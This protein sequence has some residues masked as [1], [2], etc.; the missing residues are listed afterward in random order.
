MTEPA[1]L[2]PAEALA[3]ARAQLAAAGISHPRREAYRLW[4]ELRDRPEAEFGGAV[5]RRAA[6]EPLAYVT[7]R[8]GFRHLLLA[9]DRRA[10]IPRPETEQLVDLV[11][12][13]A[14][15]GRVADIGTG[16]GCIAL[17]LAAEGQYEQVVG[18]ERSPEALSLACENRAGVGIADLHLIQGDLT[19]PFAPAVLDVLVSNPPY[20]TDA[21]WAA[22][23]PSVG[24]WE[25]RQALASGPDGLHHTRRLLDDA[26][27]VL[28]RGGLIALEIDCRRAGVVAQL[29]AEYGWRGVQ[30]IQDLFGRERFLLARRSDEP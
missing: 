19:G 16:G 17:S 5:A 24:R 6:G 12:G 22:V 4:R 20:L 2:P 21:E 25:P 11:L 3:A 8:A 9:A 1:I 30:V 29:A 23:D 18:V 28:R 10:L 7:G 15:S 13:A 27:R 14:P 26:R